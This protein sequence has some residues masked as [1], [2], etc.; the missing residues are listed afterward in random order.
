MDWWQCTWNKLFNYS[1][2][3]PL[4]FWKDQLDKRNTDLLEELAALAWSIVLLSCALCAEKQNQT[5]AF[6]SGAKIPDYLDNEGKSHL[7][8]L[9]RENKSVS[10]TRGN[11]LFFTKRKQIL[12]SGQDWY[13]KPSIIVVDVDCIFSWMNT[14]VG[15]RNRIAEPTGTI[16]QAIDCYSQSLPFPD[17]SDLLLPEHDLDGPSGERSP[18]PRWS[19]WC[20]ASQTFPFDCEGQKKNRN[21]CGHCEEVKTL[22]HDPA[23]INELSQKQMNS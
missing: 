1:L 6:R 18:H 19:S 22:L 15:Q 3:W 5:W 17:A 11:N 8:S 21:P 14:D 4:W 2:T 12:I 9:S 23:R 20:S 16:K 7:I 13:I 10:R